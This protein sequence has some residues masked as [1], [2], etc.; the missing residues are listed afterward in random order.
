MFFIA[1]K[2]KTV[3]VKL[4]VKMR[5]PKDNTVT[6]AAMPRGRYWVLSIEYWV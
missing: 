5:V 2:D 6:R 3:V 1:Q 4:T